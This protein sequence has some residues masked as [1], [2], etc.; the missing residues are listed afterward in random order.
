MT[1]PILTRT[2]D[3]VTVITLNRPE[4]LNALDLHDRIA[5]LEA[6]RDAEADPACRAIVLTG[7]DRIF[8]AGGD[9]SSMSGDDPEIARR[10]LD[11]M[12]DIARQLLRSRTPIVAAVEGGA[13]GLGLGLTC[14]A[15]LVVAADNSKYCA[16]FG[17]IGLIADTGLF[18]SLQMR[19]GKGLARRLLLTAETVPADE[20]Q[21]F[22][23]VDEITAPGEALDRAIELATL[24]ASRSVPAIA[25]TRRILSDPD[26]SLEALLTAETE[27]QIELLMGQDFDEGRTAFF[28]RRK[29]RFRVT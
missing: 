6:L 21:R 7:N 3:T 18:Y 19:A 13:Y 2:V 22:G 14:A 4:R 12:S 8:T 11:V 24:L 1:N 23:L 27:Q 29:P 28:E 15:D 26:Q 17:K 16:S 10:R 20:A 9:I 5:L 25:A